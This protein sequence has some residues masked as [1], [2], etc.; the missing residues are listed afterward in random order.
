[1][2]SDNSRHSIEVALKKDDWNQASRLLSQHFWRE[3]TLASAKYLLDKATAIPCPQDHA[4][5]RLAVSRSFTL[6]P[7]VPLLQAAALTYHIEV[8]T[9]VGGFNTYAQDILDPNSWMYQFEPQ[10]VILAIL[11]RDIIPKLWYDFPRLTPQEIRA[12]IDSTLQN[13][14]TWVEVFRSNSAGNLIIHTLETP[15]FL[16]NGIAD[17]QMEHSQVEAIR[18]INQGLRRIAAEKRGVY[19]LDYERL[20]ARH[21]GLTWGDE[22][23]WLTV[24]LPI[25]ACNLIHLA[26]EYLRFILPLMG[27]S[28]KALVVD[29]D[30]TLW[31]GV[32]GEDGMNGIKVG[33]EYPGAA[34][35]ALQRAILD[36]YERGIIL[37][38][39][40][41]NNPAEALEVFEK[42]PAMLLRQNHFAAMR[43][44]WSDKA[45]NLREIAAELNIGT[46]TL[47]F[48]DDNPA[49]RERIRLVLP[50]VFVI[51]LPDDPMGFAAALRDSPVFERLILSQED[52]NRGRYYAED[53]QRKEMQ[54]SAASL[55][56]FF[57]SLEMIA[58]I[59]PFTLETLP[60]IVQLT[61]KTNQFN[62]TTRRYAEQE[63]QE[64]VGDPAWRIY[65]IGVR[66]KFGDNGWIG[67]AILHLQNATCEIDTFLLS[68]RVIGRTVETALLAHLA[69]VARK[70]GATTLRGWFIPTPKNEPAKVFYPSHKF[71]KVKEEN[72]STLWEFDLSQPICSPEWI[73][74]ELKD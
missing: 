68:C 10:I 64:K 3:L 34:Y 41:K 39:C 27:K 13:Y 57:R 7:V 60:R 55:E 15:V 71:R 24:R 11:T 9:R 63:I 17:S 54:Q 48:L 16:S 20:V 72:G 22:Q 69:R 35:L 43:I 30:N 65:S 6:E 52:R 40:S 2:N 51:D 45:E 50:G 73:K 23:K 8:I 74:L 14:A 5:C 28:A 44:N 46:D 12:E 70:W 19:L 49:E 61:Q 66:D 18:V 58:T 37:A 33:Q 4:V 62:L 67:A 36:L 31:G 38:V 1:M 29:L 47:A 32:I 25:A 56:D 53:R 21:G 59:A 26:K 42:Y